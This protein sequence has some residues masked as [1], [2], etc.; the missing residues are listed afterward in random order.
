MNKLLVP[1]LDYTDCDTVGSSPPVGKRDG[2]SRSGTFPLFIRLCSPT[3]T[4][5]ST[6]SP[7]LLRVAFPLRHPSLYLRTPLRN[8]SSPKSRYNF[9]KERDQCF[10]Y[11]RGT[12]Y[13]SSVSFR[14]SFCLYF[15]LEISF[16]VPQT[17]VLPHQSPPS[18]GPRSPQTSSRKVCPF[19]VPWGCT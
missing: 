11:K 17:F 15:I 7:G 5:S 2:R 10:Y 8:L 1:R 13:V 3:T 16:K 4:R 19:L 14:V 18:F 9:V 6:F 12:S